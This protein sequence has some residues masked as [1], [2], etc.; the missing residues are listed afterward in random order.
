MGLTA[1]LFITKKPEKRRFRNVIPGETSRRGWDAL[2]FMPGTSGF[3]NVFAA[4]IFFGDLC[5][6]R[7]ARLTTVQPVCVMSCSQGYPAAAGLVCKNIFPPQ[8]ECFHFK[9]GFHRDRMSGFHKVSDATGTFS[10]QK[11]FPAAGRGSSC[12][13]KIPA[14]RGSCSVPGSSSRRLH[15]PDDKQNLLGG[16][17]PRNKRL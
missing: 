4:N 1:P 5:A 3:H 10:F 17:V 15:S 11:E 8:R 7:A 16:I 9:K 13:Q 12:F 14:R 2:F 6:R